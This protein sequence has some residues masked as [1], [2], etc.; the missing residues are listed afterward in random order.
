MDVL[1][2]NLRSREIADGD[3][4]PSSNQA[5]T[6]ESQ[7]IHLIQELF[8]QTLI[9]KYIDGMEPRYY[10]GPKPRLGDLSYTQAVMCPHLRRD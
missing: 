1:G 7:M 8:G 2:S 9:G 6:L 3:V 10:K 4:D 5:A